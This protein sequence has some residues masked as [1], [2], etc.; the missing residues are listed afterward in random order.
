MRGLEA[1]SLVFVRFGMDERFHMS[2]QHGADRAIQA[3]ASQN[4]RAR[5]ALRPPG[6]RPFRPFPPFIPRN[7]S[8]RNQP[9]K[10]RS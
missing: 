5:L 2:R 6:T 9:P 1:A 3:T 4:R 10:N 7:F 8:A